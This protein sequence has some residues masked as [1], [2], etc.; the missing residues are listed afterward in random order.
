MRISDWS[1]DVC[2]S[3]LD[4][5]FVFDDQNSGYRTHPCPPSDIGNLILTQTP[6]GRNSVVAVPRRLNDVSRSTRLSPKPR[7]F[8]SVTCGPSCSV[9]RI[10][11]SWHSA[12]ITEDR[13]SKRLK[14]SH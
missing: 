7:R 2:S 10:S 9:H 4:Q 11:I 6:V 12:V 14:F 1:S 3:D 8:G 13:K 5:P